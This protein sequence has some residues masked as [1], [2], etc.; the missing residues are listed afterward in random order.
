MKKKTAI[1]A[2]GL[3]NLAMLPVTIVAC[4]SGG[5]TETMEGTAPASLVNKLVVQNELTREYRASGLHEL[6]VEGRVL[7][8]L[9]V[10]ERGRV[11]KTEIAQSSGSE[12]LDQVALRLGRFYRFSPALENGAPQSVRVEMWMTF[13]VRQA[14]LGFDARGRLYIRDEAGSSTRIVAVDGVGALTAEFGRMG[15]GPGELRRVGHMVARPEGGAV[16]V[17]DGHR[18]Y[19]LFGGDG[20]FERS[21]R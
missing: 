21:V 5:R 6:G 10:N 17:D 7:V 19:L 13:E 2:L 18:A 4:A 11:T 12:P 15:D 8:F 3:A 20:S 16:L 9:H 14:D 1:I